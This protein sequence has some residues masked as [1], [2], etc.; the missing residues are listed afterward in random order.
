M[1][2]PRENVLP[3]TTD[4]RVE[5]LEVNAVG[6][7]ANGCPTRSESFEEW[8]DVTGV[9]PDGEMECDA[10]MGG[11][12]W[13]SHIESELGDGVEKGCTVVSP[14]I[15]EPVQCQSIPRYAEKLEQEHD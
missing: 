10:S 7:A 3:I 15:T 14:Y 12:A 2:Q 8:L 1:A 6:L 13:F 4:L 11:K 5:D 9:N